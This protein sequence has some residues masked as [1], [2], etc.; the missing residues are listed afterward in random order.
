MV[1]SSKANLKT[2]LQKISIF[3]IKT[4]KFDL[5]HNSPII[6]ALPRV[7]LKEGPHPLAYT[8]STL[9]PDVALRTMH[10]EVLIQTNQKRVE[11]YEKKTF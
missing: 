7:D 3:T 11:N 4:E 6:L 10:E 1:S 8:A 5:I 9:R 2:V